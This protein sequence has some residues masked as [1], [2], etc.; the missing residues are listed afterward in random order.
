[1]DS[2]GDDEEGAGE[3]DE[4]NVFVNRVDDEAAAARNFKVVL[5]RNEKAETHGDRRVVVLPP[6]LQF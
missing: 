5:K 1:V 4:R 6:V 3:P 2:A